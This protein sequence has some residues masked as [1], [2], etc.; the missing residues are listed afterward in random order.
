[1]KLALK[2]A[3]RARPILSPN[4]RVGALWKSGETVTTAYFAK[5]GGPHA[6]A[7][8]F[9]KLGPEPNDGELW[10][11]LEPCTFR[12]KTPACLDAVLERRPKRV[13]IAVL[14]PD[15]RVTGKAVQRLRRAGIPVDVGVGALESVSLNLPY[16][17]QRTQGRAWVTVKLAASLDGKLATSRGESQWITGEES[18]VDVHRDR[19]RSDAVVVGSG[20]VLADDPALTVRHVSGP[21]P[22]KIVIDS[23]FRVSP[24]CG[25]YQAWLDGS[26]EAGLQG[27]K[28][29][30]RRQGAHSQQGVHSQRGMRSQR[31][32]RSQQGVHRRQGEDLRQVVDLRQGG[33]VRTAT[34]WVRSPRLILATARGGDPD[35]LAAFRQLGW[36]VWTLPTRSGRVSL[37]ALVQKAGR[38][39]LF[40]LYAEAGPG[41]AAG[42]LQAQ[43]VDELRLYQAPLILGGDRAWS[44]NFDVG[45]LR[46]ARRLEV[47][48]TRRFGQDLKL[49]LRR[50]A[51]AQELLSCLPGWSKTSPPSKRSRK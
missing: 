5:F 51:V 16:F 20:T 17:M 7:A 32:V 23:Q 46:Q 48:E 6:E 19:S 10:V 4:P 3:S 22:S 39:G 18:R 15:P 50:P 43:L 49:T 42:L 36:E 47:V 13:S 11:T 44:G 25:I 45:R 12:G 38:E 37:P 30:H 9:Q 1:M 41:L 14:D 35:K 34:G 21:E 8:L 24:E 33:Y 40:S 26:D 2:A 31:G 27:P 28:R 29:L